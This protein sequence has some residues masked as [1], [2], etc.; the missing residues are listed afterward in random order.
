MVTGTAALVRALGRRVRRILRP[1]PPTTT[2]PQ[3]KAMQ[4][5]D[6][7][8]KAIMPEAY[9]AKTR[10]SPGPPPPKPAGVIT[11]TG[12]GRRRER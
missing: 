7:Q 1:L 4:P 5:D 2:Q 12:M 11:T 8:N 10:R 6:Y 9:A 3:T